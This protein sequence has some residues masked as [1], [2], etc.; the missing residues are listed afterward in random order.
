MHSENRI[1]TNPIT[2]CISTSL[3]PQI[4]FTC[5]KI[6]IG[7]K[8]TYYISISTYLRHFLMLC[9]S[10]WS[11]RR[12]C[13]KLYF[14][15]L[16]MRS[17][18]FSKF[19]K[20]GFWQTPLVSKSSSSIQFFHII[21]S[22]SY[23]NLIYTISSVLIGEFDFTSIRPLSFLSVQWARRFL[24]GILSQV[25]RVWFLSFNCQRNR[26]CFDGYLT[27]GLHFD[28]LGEHSSV[29]WIYYMKPSYGAGLLIDSSQWWDILAFIKLI[30]NISIFIFS[31]QPFSWTNPYCNSIFD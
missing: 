27:L 3:R 23:H 26:S 9:W 7:V 24:I 30:D 6:S 1:A 13:F 12:N 16:R 10:V 21:H 17:M 19:I 11:S 25:C 22:I 4:T 8:Y 14:I 15:Q 20:F 28:I 18:S 31:W 29:F 5:I 2:I